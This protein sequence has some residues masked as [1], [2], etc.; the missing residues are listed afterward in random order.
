MQTLPSNFRWLTEKF[1]K[2][3]E[4]HQQ[5]G[6]VVADAG[7]L[8]AKQVELIKLAAAAATQSQGSVHSHVKRALQA[9]ATPEEIY[10]TLIL[11]VS[12]VGFPITAAALSWAREILENS[13]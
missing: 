8:D 3:L 11:L 4:V 6:K 12:T 7:P 9:G 1:G 13:K 10:H 2:V 5:L